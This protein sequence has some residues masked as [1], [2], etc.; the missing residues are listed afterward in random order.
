M[1]QLENKEDSEFLGQLHDLGV[2][3]TQYLVAKQPHFRVEKE[4]V[5]AP[6][7]KVSSF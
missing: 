1:Q 3:N 2:D 6:S 5:V 4:I 7:K